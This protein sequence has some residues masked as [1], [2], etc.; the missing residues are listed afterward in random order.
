MAFESYSRLRCI[1]KDIPE[2]VRECIA[3][4][5][6]LARCGQTRQI[7]NLMAGGDVR[8]ERELIHRFQMHT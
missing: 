1:A 4:D 8:S 5:I 3:A 6:G 7:A 2:N